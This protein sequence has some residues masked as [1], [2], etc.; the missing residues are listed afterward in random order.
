MPESIGG[1]VPFSLT[2]FLG[3][4]RSMWNW[5]TLVGQ[6]LI[7]IGTN[8]KFYIS[9]GGAFNDVTPVRRTAGPMANDPFSANGDYDGHCY[10]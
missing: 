2:T 10:G 3:V 8:L 9:Q 4:C 7:G 6:N 1:W 5:A